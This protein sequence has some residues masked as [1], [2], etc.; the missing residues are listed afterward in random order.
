MDEVENER[1]AVVAWLRKDVS[2]E[3]VRMMLAAGLP[4]GT[5]TQRTKA[6]AFAEGLAHGAK[7]IADAIERGDHRE[8]QR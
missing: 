5:R 8:K 1:A 6:A 3:A 2:M 7:S 4:G